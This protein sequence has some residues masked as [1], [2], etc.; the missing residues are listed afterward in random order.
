MFN[1][2]ES[3][4]YLVDY[5]WFHYDG[6]HYTGNGVLNWN[7]DKGFH[8]AARVK[9]HQLNK[10]LHK[11]FRTITFEPSIR[12]YMRLNSGLHAIAPHVFIDEISLIHGRLLVDV[13]KVIFIQ[14]VNYPLTSGWSGSALFEINKSILLPDVVSIETKVGDG[15]PSQHYSKSGIYYVH[16]S[17]LEV[18][19]YEK[20]RKYLEINWFLPKNQWGKKECWDFAQGLQNSISVLAGQALTLKYREMYRANRIFREILSSENPS[21]LGV[22]FR[23]F[24]YGV[25][26]KEKIIELAKFFTRG[27]HHADVS[28]RIFYQMVEA[29][30]QRSYQGQEFLLSTILEAALRSI[31]KCP[32]DPSSGKSS[33]S[34]QIEYYV[35]QFRKDYLVSSSDDD[36]RWRK[37]TDKVVK[38]YKRL[39]HRNAHPDWLS[40]PGGA[41]SASEM[42]QAVNDEIFLSRFYGYMIMGLANFKSLVP[43]FPVPVAEWEPMVTITLNEPNDTQ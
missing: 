10:S 6:N 32:F 14:Q 17:G 31:Y 8:I 5:L 18:I 23:P 37:V 22:I 2:F 28:R 29:K 21:S 11:E 3:R 13:R 1:Y 40:I 15:L 16:D 41:Y 12:I 26:E 35:N 43:T 4:E 7:P 20:E 24:D 39:R 33:R 30:S 27:G 19:G 25:I 9:N 42:E 38:S 36:R 34:F